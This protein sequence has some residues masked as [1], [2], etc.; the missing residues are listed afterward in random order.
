MSERRKIEEYGVFWATGFDGFLYINT[1]FLHKGSV[2]LFLSLLF[3]RFSSL[4]PCGG[5]FFLVLVISFIDTLL[6]GV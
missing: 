6:N 4:V 5:L 3:L 1:G 2:V